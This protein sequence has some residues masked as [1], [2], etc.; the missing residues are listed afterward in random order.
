MNYPYD[1]G[2]VV[3]DLPA[4]LSGLG[5][6]RGDLLVKLGQRMVHSLDDV[7]QVLQ[8]TDYLTQIPAYFLSVVHSGNGRTVLRE[9]RIMF[10]L[11]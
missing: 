2:V 9:H 3:T 5:I 6:S 4:T 10:N 7:A 8:D 1:T 11:R